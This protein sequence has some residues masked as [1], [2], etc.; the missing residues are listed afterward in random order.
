MFTRAIARMT[1]ASGPPPSSLQRHPLSGG[2]PCHHHS[3]KAVYPTALLEAASSRPAP[4]RPMVGW[5][6]KKNDFTIMFSLAKELLWA[7]LITKN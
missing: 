3:R 7:H 4:P 2:L 6:E 1:G 5:E